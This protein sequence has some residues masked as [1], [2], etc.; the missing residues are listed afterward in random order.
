MSD[1][2]ER[3]AEVAGCPY[4]AGG[5]TSVDRRD[6]LQRLA[7]VAFWVPSAAVA[8]AS[9]GDDRPSMMD[10]PMGDDK[11]GG[12]M[13]DWMM[14]DDGMGGRM[15]RDMPVIHDLLVNHDRIQRTVRDV[16]GGIRS[17]TTSAD[18]K[19]AQLI[20][21]HVWQMKKRIEND[22]PIRQMDPLFREI[23]EHTKDI[24]IV[25][26]NLE[27]GV[28]VTETSTVAQVTLL[29]RQHARRAVSEFV[30]EGMS[31]AM[32]STP[33]PSGYTA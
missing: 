10:R 16:P 12:G 11:S 2:T 5:L 32:Q 19:L 26:R 30:A 13:P 29:I 22:D 21:T 20:Q 33:L 18:G 3:R 17:T 25:V 1:T 15:M 23:F 28:Q 9:C 14:S 31:R 24:Q 6:F 8:L 4:G 7:A 27:N